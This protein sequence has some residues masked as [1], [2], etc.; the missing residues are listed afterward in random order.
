MTHPTET[1]TAQR[2]DRTTFF[3]SADLRG[4]GMTLS[5]AN[6]TCVFGSVLL[7]LREA[8][9]A[10]AEVTLETFTLFGSVEVRVPASWR[11][12][13]DVQP[14]LGSASESGLPPALSEAS[15]TLRVTGTVLF[16]SVELER[17]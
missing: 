6:L 12:I 17:F 2:L 7:D 11:V 14:I 10:S 13:T 1:P 3:G 4:A 8:A 9:L 16:G 15:P 5:G